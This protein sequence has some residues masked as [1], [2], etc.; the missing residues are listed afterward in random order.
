[1]LSADK[2]K[3]PLVGAEIMVAPAHHDWFNQVSKGSGL[4]VQ[5]I[6]KVKSVDGKWLDFESLGR[7]ANP[8]HDGSRCSGCGELF[9][10]NV[11]DI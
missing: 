5:E 9:R 10:F 4:S 1:M 8:P 7:I 6:F 2:Y 3:G 11:L